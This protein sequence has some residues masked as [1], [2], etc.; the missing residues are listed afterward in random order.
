M[1][2]CGE[3]TAKKLDISRAQQD[4]FAL[5]SYKKSQAAGAVSLKQSE[6]LCFCCVG[7][8][9]III[10]IILVKK[11]KIYHNPK[12][13]IKALSISFPARYVKESFEV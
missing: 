8:F 6:V 9:L 2:N 4:E 7:Q 1:G 10:V 11:K 5:G 13:R 12:G 3:D